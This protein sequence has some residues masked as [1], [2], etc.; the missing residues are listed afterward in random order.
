[1]GRT[2]G[3]ASLVALA[4]CSTVKVS[5]EYDR[6]TNFKNYHSYAWILRAPGPEEAPASRDPRVRDIVIRTVDE[7]LASKG[8][9]KAGPDQSPDLLVAVHGWSVNRIDVKSY[10]YAYGPS[11]YGAYP[12]LATGAVDVRQYSDGTLLIDLIDAS[13]KQMIWR[14]TA[15]DTFEPGAEA[16][17]VSNA[18]KKTLDQ[19]P[20]A[21]N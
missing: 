21:V 15:T 8:L 13:T 14:G 12:T 4:A 3:I 5:T 2:T 17:R 19:Y 7:E 16:K 9:V 20:P 1:M 11:P 6:T 18:V 10:G